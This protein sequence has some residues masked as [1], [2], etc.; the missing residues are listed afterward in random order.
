MLSK[1]FYLGTHLKVGNNS[2]EVW[3]D[4]EAK[5]SVDYVVTQVQ[6]LFPVFTQHP[7]QCTKNS[8]C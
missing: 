6:A 7:G 1:A 3:E 5:E 2:V 8:F 4:W